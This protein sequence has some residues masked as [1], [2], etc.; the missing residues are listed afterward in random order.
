MLGL[1]DASCSSSSRMDEL[2]TQFMTREGLYR[3][4]TLSEYSRPNRVG[5]YANNSAA[6]AA[7]AAWYMGGD[8]TSA[9]RYNDAGHFLPSANDPAAAAAA[10]HANS[11]VGVG[12]AV[13]AAAAAGPGAAFL[14]ERYYQMHH[15]YETAASQG[16]LMFLILC[17]PN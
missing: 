9:A 14:Q 10:A 4:M 15:A 8:P 3:L 1:S 17:M 7:A 2:K 12:S 13:D 6:A 5:S 16:M 11:Q